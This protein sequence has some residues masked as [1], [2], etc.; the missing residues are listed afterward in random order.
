M[1]MITIWYCN[2]LSCAA[3]LQRQFSL[4]KMPI[5]GKL[6]LI[7]KCKNQLAIKTLKLQ[8]QKLFS[9]KKQDS[10]NWAQF[11]YKAPNTLQTTRSVETHLNKLQ[12]MTEGNSNS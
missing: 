8:L 10:T 6:F 11:K 1:F 12:K 9:K 3:A 7:Q 4:I 2:R 5:R